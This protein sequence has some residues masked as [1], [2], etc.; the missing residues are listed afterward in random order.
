MK[1]KDFCDRSFLPIAHTRDRYTVFKDGRIIDKLM[2][3]ELKYILAEDGSKRFL[4]ESVLG[5]HLL[6]HS[7]IV[8]LAYK[9]STIEPTHWEKLDVMFLDGD[10]SN[11][12]P[13]NLIWKYPDE[14]IE[15]LL[16]EGFRNI[17]GYSEYLI[18]EHGKVFDKKRE[19]FVT[20]K[21]YESKTSYPSVFI[22]KDLR[23]YKKST[24][25]HRLLALAFIPYGVDVDEKDVNHKDGVKTN[26]TLTN[27]E[28]SSRKENCD[29]AY[30]TGLRD[31][32][33]PILIKDIFS[34]DIFEF[35][36]D[37]DC[38]KHIGL[39][40][41][42][43]RFRSKSQGQKVYDYG[44]LIGEKGKVQ[45]KEITDCEAEVVKDTK[46]QALELTEVSTG[47]VTFYECI[48][49]ASKATK[50]AESSIRYWLKKYPADVP[51]HGYL[52]QKAKV[53]HLNKS[54]FDVIRMKKT[55]LIAGNPR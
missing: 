14:G 40:L 36:S 53:E 19:Q 35:Y 2:R 33:V 30:F 1:L 45:W 50:I 31:D 16:L 39:K 38:C 28:W 54:F 23:T 29:H 47:K 41:G 34:G 21:T 10:S 6:K 48:A 25:L 4:I 7:V 42:A 27:L 43:A 13:G 22:R 49:H 12:H 18:N 3:Q 26:Y 24:S 8:A 11:L 15:D 37:W 44:M 32:N 17:P 52:I 55:P 20:E 46:N 5:Q 51:L 9:L